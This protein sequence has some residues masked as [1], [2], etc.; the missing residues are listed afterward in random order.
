MER[1]LACEADAVGTME[2]SRFEM[3]AMTR[4]IVSIICAAENCRNGRLPGITQRDLLHS[5]SVGK[6]GFSQPIE[7]PNAG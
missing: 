3:R 7:Q 4:L 5:G 6:L 2:G 1:C